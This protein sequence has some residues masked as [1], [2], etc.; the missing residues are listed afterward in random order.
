MLYFDSFGG[1]PVVIPM[2]AF[3]DNLNTMW[4]HYPDAY[5][6]FLEAIE[7]YEFVDDI[8]KHRGYVKLNPDIT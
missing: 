3:K 2:T 8:P 5:Q 4:E 1:V 6:T 7:G